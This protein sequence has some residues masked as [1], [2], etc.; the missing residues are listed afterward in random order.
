MRLTLDGADDSMQENSYQQQECGD[1]PN[2]R[3]VDW[4][5]NIWDCWYLHL[6]AFEDAFSGQLFRGSQWWEIT[7]TV[8][9]TQI[10]VKFTSSDVKIVFAF[11]DALRLILS[12]DTPC[13]YEEKI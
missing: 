10:F 3:H 11:K 6:R 12:D 1:I 7:D 9:G 2:D 5:C 8:T 4:W 13:P